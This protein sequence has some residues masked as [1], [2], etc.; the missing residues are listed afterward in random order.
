MSRITTKTDQC[1]SDILSKILANKKYKTVLYPIKLQGMKK[2]CTPYPLEFKSGK[3]V[4][5]GAGAY[6]I[7]Y[8]LKNNK[9]IR[10]FDEK[11]HRKR[12]K[13]PPTKEDF[14]DELIG[15]Q[16]QYYLSNDANADPKGQYINKA[17]E[18]GKYNIYD[19]DGRFHSHGI[20]SILEKS[21][22][23]LFHNVI[24][25]EYSTDTKYYNANTIRKLLKNIATGIKVMHDNNYVHRDIKSENVLMKY[26]LNKNNDKTK[27]ATSIAD[28]GFSTKVSVDNF[29][30]LKDRC[31]SLE[32]FPPELIFRTHIK[33]PADYKD[34][35]KLD[36]WALGILFYEIGY[37]DTPFEY[38]EH[39]ERL[40]SKNM[41]LFSQ[42]KYDTLFFR[43]R[44]MSFDLFPTNDYRSKGGAF[45]NL[46]MD[47]LNFDPKKR[48]T[49]NEVLRHSFFSKSSSKS[50]WSKKK[51]TRSKSSYFGKHK[52]S[53]KH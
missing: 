5:L 33:K 35:F 29:D 20:Y 43:S 26:K 6:N 46:L 2:R 3:V 45:Y 23:D 21:N 9:V 16:I 31:G 24:R 41:K 34:A 49:I 52:S 10:L 4:K 22:S 51:K 53:R 42:R 13:R 27:T 7:V 50:S 17:Y 18:T 48:P 38:E 25:Y 44:H 8:Q 36:I 30:A 19:E 11:T 14:T 40:A 47:M 32:Y 28:F 12:G 39:D 1:N 15:N 37:G